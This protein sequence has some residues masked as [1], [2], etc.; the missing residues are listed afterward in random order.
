MS[1][2]SSM[3]QDISQTLSYPT[4]YDDGRT[5]FP[6]KSIIEEEGDSKNKTINT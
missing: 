1:S 5:N 2:V 4:D 3:S 6:Y